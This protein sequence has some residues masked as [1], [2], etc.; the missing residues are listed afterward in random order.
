MEEITD[1]IAEPA[2]EVKF[3]ESAVEEHRYI[4]TRVAD[5]EQ[6][7]EFVVDRIP[8]RSHISPPTY[9][10]CCGAVPFCLSSGSS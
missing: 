9:S 6:D 3:A 4:A 5:R 7:P 8:I 1:K 2:E 10:Q